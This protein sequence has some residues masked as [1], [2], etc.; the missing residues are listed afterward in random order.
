MC[1]A[2]GAVLRISYAG[3]NPHHRVHLAVVLF[4]YAV[5]RD[6]RVEQCNVNLIARDLLLDALY[7]R[8]I[9]P[10]IA[11]TVGDTQRHFIAGGHEEPAPKFFLWDFIV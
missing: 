5:Q 11:V 7:Q 9:Y 10:K 3:K 4:G 2:N 8:L 6:K 1:Q